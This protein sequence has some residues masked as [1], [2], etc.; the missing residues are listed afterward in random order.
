MDKLVEI[1]LQGL[2]DLREIYKREWPKED[3]GFYVLTNFINWLEKKLF[4]ENFHAYSLN[5][6]Y[7]DGTFVILYM[8][9]LFGHTL[10][11]DTSRLRRALCLLDLDG[12]SYYRYYYND[13]DRSAVWSFIKEKQIVTRNEWEFIWYYLTPEIGSKII[14]PPLPKGFVAETIREVDLPEVNEAW[15][16]RYPKSID[17]LKWLIRYNENIGLYTESGELAA[18]VLRY[19]FGAVAM[20]H[21]KDDFRRQGLGMYL[22]KAISKKIADAGGYAS[23]TIKEENEVSNRIFESIGYEKN[24]IMYCIEILPSSPISDGNN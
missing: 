14:V 11:K 19:E 7:S 5:G 15:L 20:L 1:P 4:V 18:W 21:V 2:I 6:D 16:F 8:T 13:Q 12:T 9:K 17:R 24:G 10:N 3:I 22:A 23:G